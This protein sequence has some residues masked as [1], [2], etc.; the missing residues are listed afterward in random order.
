MESALSRNLF[1]VKEHLGIFK[2][3]NNFD[4][5]DPETGDILL[6]CRE[7]KLGPITKILR[8][9]KYKVMTPFDVEIRTPD[10]RPVVRV[11]RGV[12]FIRSKVQVFDAT[13]QAI[14]MFRQKL[15]T[16]GGGFTV[17]DPDGQPLFDVKGKWTG[18][19]YRLMK[20]EVEFAHVTKKWGGIGKELFTSADNYII[21]ISDAVPP[22]NPVRL[23]II[24]AVMCIDMVLKER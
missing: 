11:K 13:G 16:L 20:G 18:F 3:A 23:L 8:F 24:A 10:K 19:D 7:E 21:Q 9:T 15:F 12:T 5:H 6:E 1:L 4:I 2:A 17:M 14:G 22:N